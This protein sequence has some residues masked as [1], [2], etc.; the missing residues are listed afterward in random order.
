MSQENVELVSRVFDDWK[1]GEVD[2]VEI[3]STYHPD[4]EFLPRR[5][6]T[7]GAYRGI[8]GLEKFLA[9]A[10]EIFDKF[11]FNYDLLDLGERLLAW[12]KIHLRARGSGIETDIPMGGVFEFRDGKIVRWEDF[13]SRDKA[14]RAVGLAE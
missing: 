7:E 3:H 8:A 11:E 2:E 9:D 4:V 12:G 10:E 6:A 14:L 1:L 5:A 13:G